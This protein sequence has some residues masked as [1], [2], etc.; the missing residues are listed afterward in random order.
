MSDELVPKTMGQYFEEFN[1]GDQFVTVS[2]TVTEADVA[3]F[4]GLSG[5]YNQLHTD[6][7][8]AKKSAFG[9]RVAHGFLGLSIASGLTDRTKYLEGTAMAVLGINWKFTGP[10]RLGD[11][12]KVKVVVENKRETKKPDRG[13]VTFYMAI[14]NQNDG[15]VQEGQ[16]TMMVRRKT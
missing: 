11:T 4:A 8:F 5:D 15:V 3:I 6:D 9:G 2:R 13:I 16:Q 7:E 10:I 12:I 1:V 14:L